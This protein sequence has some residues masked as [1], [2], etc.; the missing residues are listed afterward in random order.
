MIKEILMLILSVYLSFA[1]SLPAYAR[2]GPVQPERK[3]PRSKDPVLGILAQPAFE[4]TLQPKKKP[5]SKGK[6]V[7]FKSNSGQKPE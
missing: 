4:G 7:Q 1:I 5:Q 2:I 6:L 3:P